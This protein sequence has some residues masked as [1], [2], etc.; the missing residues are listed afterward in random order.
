MIAGLLTAKPGTRII[1][2][3]FL[4]GEEKR[5]LASLD[6]PVEF[7]DIDTPEER[8]MKETSDGP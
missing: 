4:P 5:L 7:E 8:K 2:N 3:G 6:I 1:L